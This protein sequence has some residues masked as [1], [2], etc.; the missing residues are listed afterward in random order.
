[1]NGKVSSPVASS[2]DDI[3]PIHIAIPKLKPISVPI[4]LAGIGGGIV[5]L[6]TMFEPLISAGLSLPG[7]LIFFALHIMPGLVIAWAITGWLFGLNSTRHL[8]PWVLIAIAGFFTGIVLAPWS[9]LLESLFGVIEMNE[10]FTSPPIADSSSF[11]AELRDDLFAVP[12]KAALTW[13]AINLTIVWQLQIKTSIRDT[14]QVPVNNGMQLETSLFTRIPARLGRDVIYLEAQEHY[15]RIVLAGGE[16][17]LLQGMANAIL[18]LETEGVKGI[19][20][21]RSYWVN[22]AHVKRIL[23]DSRGGYCELSSDVRIP[24]SRRRATIVRAAFHSFS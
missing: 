17:L 12:P 24:I 5:L 11:L 9:V 3:A 22:L 14:P 1:L 21:H 23:A 7:R 6:L 15:L 8:T 16:L 2:V 19:Q 18:E 4:Y 20:V 10:S 13:M